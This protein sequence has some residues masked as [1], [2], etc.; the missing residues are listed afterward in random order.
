MARRQVPGGPGGRARCRVLPWIASRLILSLG[1]SLRATWVN[2]TPACERAERGEGCV[3]AFWHNRLLLMP[4]IYQR[5][6]GG[7]NIC[8]MTSRSKDGQY[9]SDVL[10]GFG[11][12]LARGSTSKGGGTAAMEMVDRLKAGMDAGVT[13]DGP[14]GPLYR[15]QPGVI[16]VSQLSGVP[17][18]PLTIDAS[19]RKRLKSWDRF[20][21]PLPFSRAAV[22][23]GDPFPVPRDADEGEREALRARLEATMRE[24]D[25]KA[26]ELVGNEP[27]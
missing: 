16:L 21:V 5:I 6:R 27:D 2:D 22:I 15:V 12:E 18:L 8:V 7:K 25:R 1:T 13:P 23:L 20:I 19:R 10:G 3:F 9:I 17:I 14:R 26:A 11:F 24:L 4:W